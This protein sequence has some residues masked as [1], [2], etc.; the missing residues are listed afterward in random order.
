MTILPLLLLAASAAFAAASPARLKAVP[1][2]TMPPAYW[3]NDDASYGATRGD[4]ENAGITIWSLAEGRPLFRIDRPEKPD[5]GPKDEYN[6]SPLSFSADGRYL[7]AKTDV[8]KRDAN[9]NA[10][11]GSIEVVLIS[12]A[13]ERIVKTVYKLAGPYSPAESVMPFGPEV[14]FGVIAPDGRQATL[15]SKRLGSGG[16]GGDV[17]QE[18][19][20]SVVGLDGTLIREEAR[21]IR[22]SSGNPGEGHS[23]EW[24][25]DNRAY[26][27]LSTSVIASDGRIF[28]MSVDAA[29][30][31]LMD[32]TAGKRLAFLEDCTAK[33]G[34][35][36]N[37]DYGY[38]Y[39]RQPEGQELK[40]WNLQGGL[41]ARLTS[42][43]PAGDA[44]FFLPHGDGRY[45]FENRSK[46]GNS[47]HEKMLWDMKTGRRLAV[48]AAADD[49]LLMDSQAPVTLDRKHIVLQTSSGLGLGKTIYAAL[50]AGVPLEPSR[51]RSIVAVDLAAAAPTSAA[52]APVAAAPAPVKSYDAPPPSAVAVDPNAY[53]LVIGIEKYRQEGIPVVDFAARDARTMQSYLTGAMGFDPKNVLA[54]TDER[55]TRTDFDKAL[56]WLGNRTGAES[57]VFVFYAGHGAPNPAT[58]E[59][60]L[61]PYESDPNYLEE[62]AF[63]AAKLYAAVAKLG[64]KDATIVL[65]ACFSGLGGRS[66][67]AQGARPLVN[68]RAAKAPAGVTVL[69]AAQSNQIS[70]SDRERRHGLL[71]SYLFE[72]LHGG[73]DADGDG[74][75]MTGEVY[76]FVRAGVERAARLQNLEQTPTLSASPE[77]LAA[78][79]PWV[80]AAP[81]K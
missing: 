70:A 71:T 26:D 32:V 64:A 29:S 43:R 11:H 38:V 20:Y 36:I 50:D 69:S 28:G 48:A 39:T 62:T 9:G 10:V 2:K 55:A 33:D 1:V 52:P 51:P 5:V 54:I 56:R 74:R 59:G 13:E 3:I 7:L 60:Y 57:R 46:G 34:A 81:K 31:A 14:R 21:S 6:F 58:G 79:R 35:V 17:V 30:C 76:A 27:L 65:D 37:G 80:V 4:G 73:A 16:R 47:P 19:R 53:A 25:R 66:L 23:S 75:L 63:P 72:A 15:W 78:A 41:T 61:M 68:V 22:W 77:V 18:L 49:A 40:M 45:A 12:I 67:I 24:V 42:P 8:W 44:V